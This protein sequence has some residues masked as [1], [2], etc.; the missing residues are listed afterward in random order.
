VTG[1]NACGVCGFELWNPISPTSALAVSELSLYDDA[2]FAGRSILRLREHEESLDQ[3][4]P[5][6]ASAFMADIQKVS[7]ALRKVTGSERINVAILGNTVPH[8]HA[9]LI[10]RYAGDEQYPGKSP[11]DDPRPKAT[12][13]KD[14]RVELMIELARELS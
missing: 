7:R 8:V 6:L 14:R 11:W 12:L 2:R 10:P 13:Q 3:L 5:E 1:S 4:S 9:H